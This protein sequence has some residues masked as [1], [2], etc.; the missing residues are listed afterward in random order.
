MTFVAVLLT[1]PALGASESNEAERSPADTT[2]DGPVWEGVR[3]LADDYRSQW[4]LDAFELVPGSLLVWA[5]TRR[6]VNHRRRGRAS[7]GSW[8]FPWFGL[9][10]TLTGTGSV[11]TS[12]YLTFAASPTAAYPRRLLEADVSTRAAELY[13]QHRAE[14]ARRERI[15]RS[16]NMMTSTIFGTVYV[17]LLPT[18]DDNQRLENLLTSGATTALGLGFGLYRLLTKSREEKIYENLPTSD[19]STSTE[20]MEAS[21]SG[22][23]V[24]ARPLVRIGSRTEGTTLGAALNISW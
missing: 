8:D 6:L 4:Y 14:M 5:G 21:A 7:A 11:A 20:M 3:Q 23:D 12:L 17:L 13:L 10:F 1:S 24:R 15:A 19:A 9:Y 16:V 22:P 18:T 2:R